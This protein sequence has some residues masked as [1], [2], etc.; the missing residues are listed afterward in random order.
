MIAD[1]RLLSEPFRGVGKH[2]SRI[3]ANELDLLAGDRVAV[4]LHPKRDAMVDLRPGV[5]ELSGI[6]VNHSDFDRV[7]GAGRPGADKRQRHA[8]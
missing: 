5:G 7:L 4:L 3:L 6:L 1:D 2:A 8:G